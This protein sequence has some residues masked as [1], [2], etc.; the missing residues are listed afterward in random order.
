MFDVYTILQV[1]DITGS[2]LEY[3]L[4]H[5]ALAP[6]GS[7]ST[8]AGWGPNQARTYLDGLLALAAF[9]SHRNM[10]H[11]CRVSSLPTNAAAAVQY[12]VCMVH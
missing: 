9:S 11:A 12:F 7:D 1:G 4:S 2:A 6:N 3:L 5:T 8:A 10:L